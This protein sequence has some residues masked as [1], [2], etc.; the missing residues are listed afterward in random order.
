M[1][2]KICGIT[3][4]QDAVFSIAAGAW[5][6]GFNFYKPSKRYI[7]KSKA[8]AILVAL[9]P[10]VLKIGIFINQNSKEIS[11]IMDEVGLD[12]AQ[13]YKPIDATVSLNKNTFSETSRSPT[14][15]RHVGRTTFSIFCVY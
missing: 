3:N 7:D 4:L 13:I 6:L 8:K 14:L 11:A 10:T 9:P 2:T 12:L 1:K 15:H 5:A